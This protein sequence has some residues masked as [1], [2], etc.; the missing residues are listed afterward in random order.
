MV[1]PGSASESDA[2]HSAVAFP[3]TP[4]DDETELIAPAHL[5]GGGRAQGGER[6]AEERKRELGAQLLGGAP[7]PRSKGAA[8]HSA[9]TWSLLAT[10]ARSR[11]S[12][13][14]VRNAVSSTRASYLSRA[15]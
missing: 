13:E 9:V 10:G 4:I 7:L 12:A 6:S 8:A 11:T 3:P 1:Q 2:R 15:E 5:R 14:V